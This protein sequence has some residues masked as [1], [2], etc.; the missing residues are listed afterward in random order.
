MK[1]KKKLTLASTN[2]NKQPKLQSL[3]HC[4]RNLGS[5]YLVALTTWSLD[6]MIQDDSISFPNSK[7]NNGSQNG[8]HNISTC[9]HWATYSL[10]TGHTQL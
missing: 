9:T 8:L 3:L 7:M 5:L 4:D 6:L 1:K 10:V 2:P